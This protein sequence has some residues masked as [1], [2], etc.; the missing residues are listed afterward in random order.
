M[1]LIPTGLGG[2]SAPD[3]T[4]N[5]VAQYNLA[6][7]T[8][9]T[10]RGNTLTNNGAA[11]FGAG[12]VGNAAYL[13]AASSQYLSRADNADLSLGGG[14]SF[15]IAAWLYLSGLGS[16]RTA[17]S[18]GL[19]TT[20]GM[21][22]YLDYSSVASRFRFLLSTGISLAV[23]NA[24]ALGAPSAATWYFVLARYNSASSLASIQVNNGTVNSVAHAGGAQDTAD[25][26]RIGNNSDGSAFWDG[27]IDAVRIYKGRALS[28]A[29]GAML[30]NAGAGME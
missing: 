9:A 19:G 8:D 16:F 11:T 25:E 6:D 5:L 13:A 26:F 17:I 30:W 4:S 20:G 14:G 15:T 28:S 12:Q 2:V 3:I 23:V 22:Y 21:E 27:R 10:G 29:D 1:G 24:D 18:K 7:L